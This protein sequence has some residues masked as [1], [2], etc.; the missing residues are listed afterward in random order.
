MKNLSV[1]LAIFAG[2]LGGVF[3]HYIWPQPAQVQTRTTPSD[4]VAAQSFVL[5]DASGKPAGVF[6]VGKPSPELGKLPSIVLY[7]AEGHEIWRASDS[8]RP[9]TV[10][11]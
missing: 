10:A 3:S 9:L 4:V 5:V 6:A 7:D 2:L 1:P 8:V 11:Q